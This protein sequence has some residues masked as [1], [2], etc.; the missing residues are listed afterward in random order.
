MRACYSSV[1]VLATAVVSPLPRGGGVQNRAELI[2]RLAAASAKS[3][4]GYSRR[5]SVLPV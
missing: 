1:L 4:T 2:R 3:V 5:R